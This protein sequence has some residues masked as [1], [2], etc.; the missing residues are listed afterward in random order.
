MPSTPV[1]RSRKRVRAR[2]VADDY[3]R[4]GGKLTALGLSSHQGTY[5]MPLSECFLHNKAA[6][7]TCGSHN[8]YGH[9]PVAS[10]TARSP[11]SVRGYP[12]NGSSW[13]KTSISVARSLPM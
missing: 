6:N 10:S 7:A 3:L 11:L 13:V 9:E 2:H 1:H 12:M 4:A 5:G 8:K